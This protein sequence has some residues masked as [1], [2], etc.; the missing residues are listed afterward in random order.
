MTAN[1]C[2]RHGIGKAS[3]CKWT[4]KFG[5]LK[6]TDAK[7]PRMLGEESAKL[8]SP[9]VQAMLDMVVFKEAALKFRGA[10]VTRDAV[11]HAGSDNGL[12]ERL[13]YHLIEIA[14]RVA[15]FKQGRTEDTERSLGLR[16]LAA[17][18][19]WFGCR[20]ICYLLAWVPRPKHKKLPRLCRDGQV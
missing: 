5:D 1:V 16:E 2:H 17:A 4:A 6:V 19:W 3:F 8:R 14:W 15:R 9:L 18:R 11:A 7:R 13:A 20:R 12:S 10:S